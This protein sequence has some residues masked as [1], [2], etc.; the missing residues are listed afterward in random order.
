MLS[1]LSTEKCSLPNGSIS[2]VKLQ[3]SHTRNSC[4]TGGLPAERH[5]R[6]HHKSK[7]IF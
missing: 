1:W 4:I 6:L 5:E 7:Q 3:P 2:M